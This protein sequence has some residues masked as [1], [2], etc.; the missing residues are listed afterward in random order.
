MTKLCGIVIFVL[1]GSISGWPQISR[2]VS[3][4]SNGWTVTANPERSVLT[5]AHDQLG[6]V[7]E[8]VRLDFES[9][10]ALHPLDNWTVE[11]KSERELTIQTQ[12]PQTAWSVELGPNS[13]M[14]SST[15]GE[16]VLTARAPA[17]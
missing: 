17:S 15:S 5:I 6:T 9:E 16:G 14:I 13:L 8:D 3:I 10:G 7:L 4:S 11:E 2:P 1:L 12:E